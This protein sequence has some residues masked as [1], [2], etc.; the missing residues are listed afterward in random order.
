MRN[1]VTLFCIRHGETEW[2]RIRRFQGQRDI[3]LNERGRAQAKRNGQKL[4]DQTLNLQQLNFVASPLS[5]AC[6]TMRLVREELALDPSDFTTDARLKEAHY[7]VW[8]GQ[9]L[10]TIEEDDRTSLAERHADPFN[11]RPVDGESSADLMQRTIE[12]LAGINDDT[13]VVTHGGVSR[14]LRIHLLGLDANKVLELE[15]PQDRILV[16]RNGEMHWI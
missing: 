13:V 16:L 5:R 3:P 10:S 6:E 7:G 11:W 8:E 9:L 12:W 1:G 14:V 4:A 2:N 15:V